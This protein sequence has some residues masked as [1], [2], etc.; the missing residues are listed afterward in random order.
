[1]KILQNR[2]SIL[3]FRQSDSE[4]VATAWER[5][6]VMLTT[7]PSHGVDEWTILHS[8]Y[9]GLNYMSRSLLDSAEGGAFMTKTV[10]EAK[11]ILENMLQNYSQWHTDRAPHTSNKKFTSMKEVESLSSKLDSLMAMI[12]KQPNLDNV[13][14]QVLVANNAEGVDV[15]YIIFLAT[16]LVGTTTIVG[17]LDHLLAK[18][19]W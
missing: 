12:S 19:L 5:L 3:A 16:M 18:H 11:V 4:H 1:V 13:P 10:S 6:N 8:F 2:N 9:N 17:I 15:N 14:L 7:C